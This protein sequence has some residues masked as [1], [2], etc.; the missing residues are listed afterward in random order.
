MTYY[1]LCGGLMM[2]CFVVSLFFYKFWKKT[3]DRLF[4]FFSYAFLLLTIERLLLGMLG[5]AQEPKPQIY[6]IRLGAFILILAGIII[7]N[8][9]STR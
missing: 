4:L 6:L 3:S 2:G 1:I 9:E 8:R 5:S 7:K